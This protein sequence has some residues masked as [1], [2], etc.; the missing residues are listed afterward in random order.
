MPITN[1][2]GVPDWAP[3]PGV[4]AQALADRARASTAEFPYSV[5]RALHFSNGGGIYIARPVGGGDQ[6]VLKEARPHAGLDQRGDD[7]VWTRPTCPRASG[8]SSRW[9]GSTSI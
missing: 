6:V 3:V 5:E 9:R 7:A 2:F 8:S 1:F 4:L